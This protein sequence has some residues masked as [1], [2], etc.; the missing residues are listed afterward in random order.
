MLIIIL[1]GNNF[2]L[3]GGYTFSRPIFTYWTKCE[4]SE[5][6]WNRIFIQLFIWKQLNGRKRCIIRLVRIT[7]ELENLF[8]IN[9]CM[10][11]ADTWKYFKSM[12]QTSPT[13]IRIFLALSTIYLSGASCNQPSVNW[14]NKRPSRVLVLHSLFGDDAAWTRIFY[15]TTCRRVF[16]YARIAMVKKFR[17]SIASK[18][19]IYLACLHG[20]VRLLNLSEKIAF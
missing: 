12:A 4:I 17:S 20:H 6:T 7:K 14:L 9:K 10:Q 8:R 1:N 3:Q 16:V 13:R 11:N 2:K 15:Y 5:T 19:F 18:N